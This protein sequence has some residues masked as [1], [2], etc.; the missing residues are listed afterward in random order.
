MQ[1]GIIGSLRKSKG[2]DELLTV[3]KKCREIDKNIDF[4]IVG[5]FDYE[6]SFLKENGFTL[7]DDIDGSFLSRKK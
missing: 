1:I 5:S 6:I 2:L 4:V 7:P 3:V